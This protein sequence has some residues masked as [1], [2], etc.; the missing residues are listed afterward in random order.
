MAESFDEITPKKIY[1]NNR[2]WCYLLGVTGKKFYHMIY[3]FLLYTCPYAVMLVI[4]I[5]ERNN[6]SIIY[7]LI[8]TSFLY[9]IQIISTIIGGC[10][11]PGILA[12]QKQD[13]YLNHKINH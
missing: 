7:P 8:I 6:L 5:I 13:Y 4:L 11:D 10:S 9:I 2:I 1:G 3:A 12:R